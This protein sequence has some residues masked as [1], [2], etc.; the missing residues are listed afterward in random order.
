MNKTT[1]Y[2][3]GLELYPII[4]LMYDNLVIKFV[5]FCSENLYLLK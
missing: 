4:K 3:A 5:H 1:E 2:N